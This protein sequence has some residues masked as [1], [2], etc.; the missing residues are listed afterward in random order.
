MYHLTLVF[1]AHRRALLGTGHLDGQPR[2]PGHRGGAQPPELLG[3]LHKSMSLK[4]TQ[5]YEPQLHKS[6]SLKYTQVY[7]PCIHKSMSLTCEPSSEQATS[8]DNPAYLGIEAVLNHQNYWV[9]FQ[10]CAPQQNPKP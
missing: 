7:E 9:D 5:V 1:K 8:T 10:R 2:V 4:Y 6:M 3:R